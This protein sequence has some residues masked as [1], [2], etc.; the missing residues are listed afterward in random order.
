MASKQDIFSTPIKP[1]KACLDEVVRGGA[2]VLANYLSNKNPGLASYLEKEYKL[3]SFKH[4]TITMSSSLGE[5]DGVSYKLIVERQQLNNRLGKPKAR[6]ITINM[7][8]IPAVDENNERMG[9]MYFD[10]ENRLDLY[11]GSLPYW[12]EINKYTA[13]KNGLKIL[14]RSLMMAAAHEIVHALQ[15]VYKVMDN[16]VEIQEAQDNR[17]NAKSPIE[18]YYLDPEE[19]HPMLLTV[20]DLFLD[21]V[22][23]ML[24][25]V[26]ESPNSPKGQRIIADAFLIITGLS[27]RDKP[28]LDAVAKRYSQATGFMKALRDNDPK[29]WEQA[30]TI[31]MDEVLKP[32]LVSSK[33][34]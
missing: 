19:Y 20:V 9:G 13:N 3:S 18:E 10:K 27:D 5:T 11:L 33:N 14:L 26:K 2:R 29:R 17:K 6:A 23:K 22:R 1:S 8:L 32:L 7:G 30:V 12:R 34:G 16:K 4:T 31:L 28:G 15:E 25:K 21:H 24:R